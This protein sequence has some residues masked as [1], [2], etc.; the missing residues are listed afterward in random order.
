MTGLLR[1]KRPV[2]SLHPLEKQKTPRVSVICQVW[3]LKTEKE[4]LQSWCKA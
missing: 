4:R 1:G 3:N 2:I